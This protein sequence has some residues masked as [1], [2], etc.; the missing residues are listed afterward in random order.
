MR[1][2]S[3]QTSDAIKMQVRESDMY[4]DQPAKNSY[5]SKKLSEAVI[6]NPSDGNCYAVALKDIWKIKA[7]ERAKT[8]TSY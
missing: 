3:V 2:H 4:E 1:F 8:S 5:K 7:G 6:I